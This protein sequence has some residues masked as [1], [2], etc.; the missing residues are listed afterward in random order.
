M[1]PPF[2]T[3][4]FLRAVSGATVAGTALLPSPVV[5][6]F[7]DP[8]DAQVSVGH[9]VPDTAVDVHVDAALEDS[10]PGTV[11]ATLTLPAGSYDLKVT[12]AGA[13]A[14]A[15]SL[16]DAGGVDVPAGANASVEA[17]SRNP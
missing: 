12:E 8:Q 3:R 5:P 13:G 4:R 15:E 16:I 7:P 17:P 10:R 9:A 2:P 6:A 1:S 14:D 11:S